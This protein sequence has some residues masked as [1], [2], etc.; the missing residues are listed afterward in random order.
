MH[1][2]GPIVRPQTDA[3]SIFVE[4]DLQEAAAN[5]PHAKTLLHQWPELPLLKSTAVH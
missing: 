4:A 5:F 2:H 1:Y 3:D